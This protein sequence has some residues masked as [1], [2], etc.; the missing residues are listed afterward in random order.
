[1]KSYVPMVLTLCLVSSSMPLAAQ[2]GA[3]VPGPIRRH[4]ELP[5][6]VNTV[7]TAIERPADALPLALWA[8]TVQDGRSRIRSTNRV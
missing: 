4:L 7:A 1:M 5:A 3:A 6:P 8:T 2:R